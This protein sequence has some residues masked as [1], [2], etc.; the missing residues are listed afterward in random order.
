MA[1]WRGDGNWSHD[2]DGSHDIHR[3]TSADDWGDTAG[4]LTTGATA[5]APT[6]GATVPETARQR[7][8]RLAKYR[9]W[10]RSVW[11][12]IELD[13]ERR[14]AR[15][16]F[17]E[18]WQLAALEREDEAV[19]E[20]QEDDLAEAQ[21]HR[22]TELPPLS[23]RS[24]AD[25]ARSTSAGP[26]ERIVIPG[27]RTIAAELGLEWQ[28]RIEMPLLRAMGQSFCGGEGPGWSFRALGQRLGQEEFIGTVVRVFEKF[29]FIRPDRPVTRQCVSA[30][31]F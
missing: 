17:E 4:A 28:I 31:N 22:S 9:R 29:L 14:A 27:P 20:E 10:A 6:A 2:G 7:Q 12:R 25:A 11:R 26:A 16:A 30:G 1:A 24:S 3:G 23:L 19:P 5:G 8:R 15:T 21:P 13:H 18:A